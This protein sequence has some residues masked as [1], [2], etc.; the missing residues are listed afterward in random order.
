MTRRTTVA[1]AALSAWC[2]AVA[3]PTSGQTAATAA[4]RVGVVFDWRGRFESD[5][6][7]SREDG[8]PRDDR[9]RARTRARLEVR[10]GAGPSLFVIGRQHG[11]LAW[12]LATIRM[13]M[14]LSYV[15]AEADAQRGRKGGSRR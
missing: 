15:Y 10:A 4:P 1:T 7:S 6:S 13:E 14:V 3:Q 12:S 9:R 5:V 2:L 8:T 11:P